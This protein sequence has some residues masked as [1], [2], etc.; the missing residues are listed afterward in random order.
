MSRF[1][2]AAS[3]A[4]LLAGCASQVQM[5]KEPYTKPSNISVTDQRT[6]DKLIHRHDALFSAIVYLGDDRFSPRALDL[7]ANA[8]AKTISQDQQVALEIEEFW[9]IDFYPARLGAGGHGLL[10]AMIIESLMRD[11]TDWSFVKD[12]QFDRSSDAVACILKGKL[13]GTPVRVAVGE[14]Y[15]ASPF[16][17]IVYNDPDFR[18]AFDAV[19][20]RAAAES[21]SQAHL[22]K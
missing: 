18:R 11:S 3:I 2:V 1:L 13:N 9:I 10:G 17:G 15:R 21:L 20:L 12:M 5:S 16:G 7:Y 8:L 19:L 6:A 22:T 4:L 14:R